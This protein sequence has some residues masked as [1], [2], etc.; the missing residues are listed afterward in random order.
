MI[1]WQSVKKAICWLTL[2]VIAIM[3]LSL[4]VL[5]EEANKEKIPMDNIIV[6][7]DHIDGIDGFT[8]VHTFEG[9]DEAIYV[10]DNPSFKT[11]VEKQDVNIEG[12][13]DCK[14]VESSEGEFLV[15]TE[16]PELI[17]GGLS[18]TYVYSK[19]NSKVLGFVI[20]LRGG[21]VRCLTIN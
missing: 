17:V 2:V 5:V 7:A 16:H 15:E 6:T 18:G 11:V 20:E 21:K 9:R 8:K 19:N 14:I 12:L 3:Y 13:P 4:R 10:K 1:K